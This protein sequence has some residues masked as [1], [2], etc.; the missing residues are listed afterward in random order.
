MDIMKTIYEIAYV[1]SLLTIECGITCLTCIQSPN[2]CLT[3]NDLSNRV[4]QGS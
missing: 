1:I 2:N 4:K 3:C